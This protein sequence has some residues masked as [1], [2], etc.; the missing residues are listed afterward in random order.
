[1][2]PTDVLTPKTSEECTKQDLEFHKA[3]TFEAARE[4]FT[5]VDQ[6][7][8]EQLHG[9][10]ALVSVADP[11]GLA[12]TRRAHASGSLASLNG[13]FLIGADNDMTDGGQM[14]GLFVEVQDGNGS[15]QEARV[16]GMLP[17]MKLP[18]FNSV[19]LKPLPNGGHGDA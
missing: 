16:G 12:G 17:V 2:H 11:K 14:L 4:S 13:G 18:G 9:A 19:F 6:Q 1:M 5:G 7:G 10:L 8:R 15:F 3:F